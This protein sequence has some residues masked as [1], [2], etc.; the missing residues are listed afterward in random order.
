MI[1]VLPDYE[2]LNTAM[3]SV[4]MILNGHS[5]CQ[6]LFLRGCRL[7]VRHARQEEEEKKNSAAQGN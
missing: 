2:H 3:Y 6:R 7:T 4:S 5:G 1:V